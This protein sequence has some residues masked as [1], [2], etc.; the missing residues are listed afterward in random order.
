M[1]KQMFSYQGTKFWMSLEPY[2][3]FTEVL[4]RGLNLLGILAD[5][6]TVGW[7]EELTPV[8]VSPLAEDG[9]FYV[10][11]LILPLGY[12]YEDGWLEILNR[13]MGQI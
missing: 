10:T 1:E 4:T 12:G 3:L 6:V 8:T 2:T 7:S 11:S 9:M 13:L 5:A